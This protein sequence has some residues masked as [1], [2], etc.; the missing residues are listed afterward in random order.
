MT[1]IIASEESEEATNRRF[2]G[3]VILRQ[4]DPNRDLAELVGWAR[5]IDPDAWP[6]PTGSR[7]TPYSAPAWTPPPTADEEFT[8]VDSREGLEALP[9]GTLVRSLSG[10]EGVVA[11]DDGGSRRVRRLSGP[12]FV[13]SRTA[14]FPILAVTYINE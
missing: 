12:D 11:L 1:N 8:Y 13:D 14:P 7:L 4:L 5:L 9:L 2:A 6:E 3:L 10:S